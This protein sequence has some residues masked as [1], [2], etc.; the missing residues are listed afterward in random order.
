MRAVTARPVRAKRSC[1]R[2]AC[3][4]GIAALA[5]APT[6]C[7]DTLQDQPISHSTLESLLVAPYAV[8]WL[9]RSFDGLSLKEASRDPSGAFSVAYGDCRI[10]GQGTCVPPLRVVT[11][12]DNSFLPGSSGVR[13]TLALRGVNGL[14]AE[15]GRA[16]VL[17]TGG[18]VIAIYALDR[19]VA[20]AAAQAVAP[21]NEPGAPG[22]A[23]PP[24]LP[25]TGFGRTPLR[26]QVPAPLA[27]PG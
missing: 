23:L 1:R 20:T 24:A 17:P 8:F 9:G 6:G 3:S 12:P 26:A 27:P 25:D 13:A 16:I 21:L 2:L 4:L 7:G 22:A 15:Q 18:V 10:G 5:L 14:S 19:R 11:S